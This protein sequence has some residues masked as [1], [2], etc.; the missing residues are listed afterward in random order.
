MRM[1]LS[2]HNMSQCD[3]NACGKMDACTYHEVAGSVVYKHAYNNVSATVKSSCEREGYT[4]ICPV[5]VAYPGK[6]GTT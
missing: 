2:L 4:F 1:A 5:T 6:C 3:T